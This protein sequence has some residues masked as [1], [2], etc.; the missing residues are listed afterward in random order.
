[1]TIAVDLGRKATKQTNKQAF[2]KKNTFLFLSQNICCGYSKEPSQ[3]DSS[4]EHPKHRLKLMGK[5]ILTI[6]SSNIWFVLSKPSAVGNMSINRC[7]FYCGSRGREFDPGLVLYFSWDWS[8]SLSFSYLQLNNS[9]SYKQKNVQ[10][11]LVNCLFKLARKSMVRW[12][13][14]PAMTIAVDLG[15]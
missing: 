11:V 10:E 2:N 6:L 13:D 5:K 7:R 14:R 8:W 15:R 3:W 1:M 9:R 12:I 4:L